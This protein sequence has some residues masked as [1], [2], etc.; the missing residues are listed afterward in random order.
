MPATTAAIAFSASLLSMSLVG[1]VC[2]TDGPAS[3]PEGLTA[4]HTLAK[5]VER[6]GS[7]STHGRPAAGGDNRGQ[8]SGLR[9]IGLLTVP[10][11]GRHA[12]SRAKHR[13]IPPRRST[14]TPLGLPSPIGRGQGPVLPARGPR[15]AGRNELVRI[16]MHYDA[17]ARAY[18]SKIPDPQL[19]QPRR[20]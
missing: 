2:I 12:S 8:R 10:R 9:W 20:R 1:S 17:L 19:G 7:Q 11:S 18:T 16:D 14:G 5:T 4:C 13:Q 15:V 6:R 3:V